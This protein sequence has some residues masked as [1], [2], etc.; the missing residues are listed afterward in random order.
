MKR[1]QGRIEETIYSRLEPQENET[2]EEYIERIDDFGYQIEGSILD[3][4]TQE[5]F[6]LSRTDAGRLSIVANYIILKHAY[7]KP[8]L[9][10]RCPLPQ[11]LACATSNSNT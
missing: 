4:N 8:C 1:L 11:T 6:G 5:K 3:G 7:G 9:T 2:K 10:I